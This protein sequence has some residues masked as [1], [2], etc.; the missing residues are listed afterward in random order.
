MTCQR[1][2]SAWLWFSSE[3]AVHWLC[4]EEEAEEEEK[5]ERGGRGRR[6]GEGEAAAAAAAARKVVY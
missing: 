6:E 3:T 2:L 1:G 5:E 4:A